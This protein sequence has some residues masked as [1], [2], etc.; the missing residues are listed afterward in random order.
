ML[1]LICMVYDWRRRVSYDYDV[2]MLA[3]SIGRC[4][5][6]KAINRRCSPANAKQGPE[7]SRLS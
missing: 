5:A 7:L 6:L 4:P 2:G 1:D 3:V